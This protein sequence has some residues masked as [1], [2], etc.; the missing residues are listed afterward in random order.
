MKYLIKASFNLEGLEGIKSAGA[1]SRISAVE[2]LTASVGG[3][4]EA[5]YFAFGDTDAY[6]IVD[7]PDNAAAAAVAG[8]VAS[9]GKIRAYETV[10]LITPEEMDEAMKR[11]VSYRP[12]GQ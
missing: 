11:S 8:V 6:V 10:V 9:S 1:S 3:S 12:P 4:L 7:L 5:Y 2:E